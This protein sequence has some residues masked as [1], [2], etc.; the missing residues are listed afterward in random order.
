MEILSHY[1]SLLPKYVERS[2][3]FSKTL[4]GHLAKADTPFEKRNPNI[5]W[6]K[7]AASTFKELKIYLQ[8]SP[9]LT[10]LVQVKISTSTWRQQMKPLVLS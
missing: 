3:T 5:E 9:L 8:I 7:K 10:R 4:R 6:N 1:V 2:L